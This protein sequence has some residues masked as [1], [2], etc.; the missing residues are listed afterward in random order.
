MLFVRHFANARKVELGEIGRD[1][2]I[3]VGFDSEDAGE[4]FVEFSLVC[5]ALVGNVEQRPGWIG[6]QARCCV[7]AGPA[8]VDDVKRVHLQAARPQNA[9]LRKRIGIVYAYI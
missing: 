4:N 9:I 7:P 6:R 1:G 8:R 5:V 2:S 3:K